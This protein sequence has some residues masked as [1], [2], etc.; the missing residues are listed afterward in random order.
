M[1]TLLKA[2]ALVLTSLLSPPAVQADQDPVT[3]PSSSPSEAAPAHEFLPDVEVKYKLPVNL[4]PFCHETFRGYPL[5]LTDEMKN[6]YAL[7]LSPP[8]IRPWKEQFPACA[9]AI[10]KENIKVVTNKNAWTYASKPILTCV[11]EVIRT[12][13]TGPHTLQQWEKTFECLVRCET[14]DTYDPFEVTS[15]TRK[16]NRQWHSSSAQS[17]GAQG[18]FQFLPS[19]YRSICKGE[20]SKASMTQ[21]GC[22]EGGDADAILSPACNTLATIWM[23][24]TGR[25]QEWDCWKM[26]MKSN[27]G[28]GCSRYWNK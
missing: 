20:D 12:N 18:L 3:P 19:T 9:D 17:S 21:A 16:G 11:N 13:F 27:G 23:Y 2:F 26:R 10:K 5:Q 1:K 25:N 15:H 24:K 28:G 22:C 7:K 8:S 6:L 4:D 14:G